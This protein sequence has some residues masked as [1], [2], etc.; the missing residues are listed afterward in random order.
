PPPTTTETTEPKTPGS[1]F[2]CPDWVQV[3]PPPTRSTRPTSVVIQ[4][5]AVVM[6]GIFGAIPQRW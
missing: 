6:D 1:D 4:T 5:G 2:T 3:H